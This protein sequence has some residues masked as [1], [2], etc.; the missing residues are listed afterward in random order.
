MH[1]LAPKSTRR[2]TGAVTV[3]EGEAAGAFAASAVEA[4]ND[5]LHPQPA[6]GEPRE[7]LDI[8]TKERTASAATT[9]AVF[10]NVFIATIAYA[11]ICLIS[12]TAG[13]L[14]LTL[15]TPSTTSAGV[16]MTPNAMIF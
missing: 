4:Y 3:G 6:W 9:N 8:Q 1:L 14:P 15:T 7:A 16:I 11:S 12:S 5:A 10:D 13:T 2:G